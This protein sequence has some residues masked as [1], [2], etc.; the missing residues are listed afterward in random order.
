VPGLRPRSTSS[1]RSTRYYNLPAFPG[2]VADLPSLVATDSKANPPDKYALLAEAAS[3]S[4]N[5]GHPGHA[6]AAFDEVFN[7]HLV[8]KMFAAAAR[9]ELSAE[10]AVNAA[11]AVIRPIYDKWR[12]RGKV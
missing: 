5:F 11:E 4:T 1:Q 10:D 12:E 7:Q 6:N 2:S 3:W 9:G 8:P